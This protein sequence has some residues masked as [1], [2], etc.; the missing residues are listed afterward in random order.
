MGSRHHDARIALIVAC[1]KAQGG[2]RHKLIINAHVDAV[3]RQ[4]TRCVTRKVPALQSAVVADGDRLAAALCLYPV[5]NALGRLA[6]YPDIHAVRACA[7]RSAQTRRTK[8]QSHR[9]PIL[10]S[11]IIALDIQ[12]LF[13]Q[14]KV[15]Q[16]RF[17]PAL[18]VILIHVISTLSLA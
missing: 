2:N 13:V 15:Y 5:R 17:Q 16:I 14:V 3:R 1:R 10:D 9:K 7:Q 18:V 4:H 11:L 12:K 8:L 6:H